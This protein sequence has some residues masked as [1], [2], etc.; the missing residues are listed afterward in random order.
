MAEYRYNVSLGQHV[1]RI[2]SSYNDPNAERRRAESLSPE[3]I[4]A[5]D[6]AYGEDF[7]TCAFS[8]Q[9]QQQQRARAHAHLHARAQAQTHLHPPLLRPFPSPCLSA[10]VHA[11]PTLA[12]S[13]TFWHFP[14]LPRSFAPCPAV[15]TDNYTT[16]LGANWE[17][18][19]KTA[20][21]DAPGSQSD[22]AVAAP[23]CPV[24]TL[25]FGGHPYVGMWC[26]TVGC[27]H[28]GCCAAVAV[29]RPWGRA[30]RFYL[31][32]S[33]HVVTHVVHVRCAI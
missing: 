15:R 30:V 7:Q 11:R 25:L 24:A 28:E 14:A 31:A 9:Q 17:E 4:E 8:T 26:S 2:A 16:C 27:I 12:P 3:L 13:G 33:P 1:S 23:C 22:G 32:A 20:V 5:I 29:T 19:K 21:C 6:A 10:Y 18:L